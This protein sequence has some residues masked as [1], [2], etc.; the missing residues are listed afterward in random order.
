MGGAVALGTV[1]EGALVGPAVAGP[2]VLSLVGGAATHA[3]SAIPTTI[4]HRQAF[5]MP[6][7]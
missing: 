6:A 3:A 2:S 7:L 4:S 5:A 1:A